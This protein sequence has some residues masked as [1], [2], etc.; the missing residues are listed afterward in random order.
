MGELGV[1]VY[2]ERSTFDKDAAYL[3][4]AAALGYRRVFT[5][6]LEI[7]GDKDAVLA[8]FKRVITHA[9]QLGLKVMVDINPGLFKQLGVSYDDLAFF[10]ALGAWGIRLDVGFNGMVEAAMTRNPY[11]LKIEVNMS[12]GTP[13]IDN[14]MA[15][16]PNRANLLG[17]HN[18]YPHRF[19]GLGVDYFKQ[20]SAPF[21]KYRIHTAAFL[22]A[23]SAT[24]GPWPT[25]DGLP[26]LEAHRTMPLASQV[27][28]HRLLG[29]ADDL[30]IANAYAD[31][32]ELKAAAAAFNQPY[33]QL[34]VTTRPGI[35]PVE[36]AILFEGQHSYR[37]DHSEYLLRSAASRAAYQASAIP[38]HDTTA[39]HRGDV[40]IDNG[41][42]GQYK[43]EAEIAL[44][45]MPNDGRVNVVGHLADDQQVL[46]N[47]LKPWSDFRFTA[48]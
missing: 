8:G 21:L 19:A 23:H 12:Q 25:Q 14:I 36:R 32:A 28:H 6:L 1:S 17:S 13:L 44:Q 46:M 26:T 15:F 38:A 37:G 16:S 34:A 29:V 30:I 2:P 45:D 10:H 48:R 43:G 40:L 4:L 47:A 22:N 18:F 42:Y 27:M 9:N 31:E 20:A 11:N 33:P 7:K 41:G 3:G 24:F 39:I 5:S 35:L